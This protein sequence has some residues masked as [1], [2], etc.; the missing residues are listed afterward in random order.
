MTR[1]I[2]EIEANDMVMCYE[3]MERGFHLKHKKLRC[4]TY[5]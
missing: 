3:W 1:Q 5:D 4:F 2:G